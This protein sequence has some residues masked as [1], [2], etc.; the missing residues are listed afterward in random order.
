[1]TQ[2]ILWTLSMMYFIIFI[3]FHTK[4]IHKRKLEQKKLLFS[5]QRQLLFDRFQNGNEGILVELTA[6]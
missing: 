2:R 5:V 6:I 1:M 3:D 4:F